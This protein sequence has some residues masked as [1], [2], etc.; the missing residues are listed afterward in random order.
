M[1]LCDGLPGTG[2][3]SPE[4]DTDTF[5]LYLL[6]RSNTCEAETLGHLRPAAQPACLLCEWPEDFRQKCCSWTYSNK[7]CTQCQ[8]D[9]IKT[10]TY[11]THTATKISLSSFKHTSGVTSFIK[12]RKTH[13]YQSGQGHPSNRTDKFNCLAIVN[14][15]VSYSKLLSFRLIIVHW[16]NTG[17]NNYANCFFLW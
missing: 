8:T 4:T 15:A 13:A 16:M 10:E 7:W 11:S 2:W 5:C 3:S 1:C 17:Y 12:W 9:T 14:I 6:N